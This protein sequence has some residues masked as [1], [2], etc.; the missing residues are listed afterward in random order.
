[1]PSRKRLGKKKSTLKR[2][3]KKHSRKTRSNR[4]KKAGGPQTQQL[5]DALANLEQLLNNNASN[6][7]NDVTVFKEKVITPISTSTFVTNN[8]ALVQKLKNIYSANIANFSELNIQMGMC[9]QLLPEIYNIVKRKKDIEDRKA[10]MYTSDHKDLLVMR[11]S[12]FD[13]IMPMYIKM[14]TERQM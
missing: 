4:G 12:I 14:I 5:V 6:F 10:L 8:P 2:R 9:I 13:R 1:M 3:E 7:D 11:S